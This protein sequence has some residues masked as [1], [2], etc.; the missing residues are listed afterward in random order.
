VG[1]PNRPELPSLRSIIETESKRGVD[2]SNV[3]AFSCNT[4]FGQLG[5]QLGQEKMV[6]LAERFHIFLPQNAPERNGDFT[7][8]SA[9]V[10]FLTAQPNFLNN[11]LALADTAFGQGQLQVT[12]MQMALMAATVANDGVMPQAYLVEKVTDPNDSQVVLY[13]HRQ[14]RNLLDSRRIISSQVAVEMRKMMREGVTI[15]FGKAANVNNSGGKSGSGEAG[16]GIIH[17]AFMSVAPVD[18]PRYVVYVQI[19]NGRDGAGVGARTAG[20]ILK[21]AF[22]LLG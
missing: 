15:G 19:E 20:E 8:L 21:A 3:F 5:V 2:L 9:Q 16:E 7:D 17:A 12:P 14:P 11:D 6:E 13:Q 1:P 10:S 18:Q 4:A 22:E